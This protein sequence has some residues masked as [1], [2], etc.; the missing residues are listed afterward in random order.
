MGGVSEGEKVA[1][2]D[3]AEMNP[4][5]SRTVAL[6]GASDAVFGIVKLLVSP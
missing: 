1:P 4:H 2:Q 5:L 3:F 6:T